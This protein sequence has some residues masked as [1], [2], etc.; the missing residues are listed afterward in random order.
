MGNFISAAV[1]IIS[2][3]IYVGLLVYVLTL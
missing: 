3:T 2:A 1:L